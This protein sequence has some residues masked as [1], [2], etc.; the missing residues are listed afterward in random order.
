M[1]KVPIMLKVPISPKFFGKKLSAILQP[2]LSYCSADLGKALNTKRYRNFKNVWNVKIFK[3]FME[4]L[5]LWHTFVSCGT[6]RH[7]IISH[8]GKNPAKFKT[9]TLS[10]CHFENYS[11]WLWKLRSLSHF[12]TLKVLLSLLIS[13]SNFYLVG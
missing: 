5:A 2:P 11:V 3:V 6:K 13:L 1:H 10:F 9:R 8:F 12:Y 7:D 4:F